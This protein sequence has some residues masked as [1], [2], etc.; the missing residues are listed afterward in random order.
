M[1]PVAV[2]MAPDAAWAVTVAADGTVRTWGTAPS[3]VWHE[4]AID[5]GQP[6]AVAVSGKRVR[7][8]WA[9]EGSI[10][11]HEPVE[12]AQPRE[13]SFP[14]QAA[15]RALALSPS[16]GLAVVACDDGTLRSLNTETG[17]F[18]VTLASGQ[19]AALAVAVA[20]DEGPA[21]AA[22]PDGS[23]H[24]Y[25]LATG[26]SDIVATGSGI[27]LVA[28][29]PDGGTVIAA[30]GSPLLYGKPGFTNPWFVAAGGVA[31]LPLTA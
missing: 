24:R 29:T 30:D 26:T 3:V 27:Y 21:V 23:V 17:E 13:D 6:V 19:R 15:V 14:V 20:S 18:G 16:G 1:Q 11:L 2:A 28:V 5:A 10:R 7:V 8:L 25:D 22:F 12:G 4:V 9:A 31:P